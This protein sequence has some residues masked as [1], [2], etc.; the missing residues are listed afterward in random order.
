MRQAIA[1]LPSIDEGRI[2]AVG[3]SFGGWMVNF[4]A[5]RSQD[6][7]CVVSH[8]GIFDHRAMGGATDVGPVWAWEQASAPWGDDSHERHSPHRHIA[9]WTAPTLVIHGERDYRV[10]VDQGLALFEALQHHGVDAEY[11][12][13]PDEG[14]WVHRPPNVRQFHRVVVDF[15]ARHSGGRPPAPPLGLSGW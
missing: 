14:H 6:F 7:R 15:L 5:G 8:A 12:A 13:F 1:A 3:A 10:P 9:S 4:L 11:L 2:S